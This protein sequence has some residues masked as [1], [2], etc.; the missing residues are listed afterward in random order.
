MIYICRPFE[1][2]KPIKLTLSI[3][4]ILLGGDALAGPGSIRGTV[5]GAG[6]ALISA[7]VA[8][9]G[10]TLGSSTDLQG[11]FLISAVEPGTYTLGV[12]Y[13]GHLPLR[14]TVRVVAD[15]VLDL[16]TLIMEPTANDLGEVVV[17]GTMKEMSRA[18]SPIPVEV[19]TP[20][21]F[22][23][24]P[25]PTLIGSV[26]M[27][28]GVRP[29]INCS[30]CNTG[31]IHING[32]EGP[33]TMVLI[34]GMPIVSGLSTVYGLSGIPTSLVERVEVVKGPGS[35]LYGSEAMGG[36]INVIT[37]DPALAPRV[38]VDVMGS[39][40]EEYNADLGATVRRGKVSNL[41]GINVFAYDA[42]RDNNGDGFTDMT[43]QK[44]V[45]IFNKISY[46][47]PD[48]KA[49]SLAARYVQEDRWGGEMDWTPAFAGSDLRYGETIATRRWEL[50]GQYQLPVPGTVM[51][52]VSMNGH[53]QESWYGTTPFDAVQQVFFGQLFWNRRWG[54]RH[55]VLTGLAY[56]FTA[57]NDNTP[58]TSSG[59]EPYTTD[60]PQ[61]KPMPGLFVQ[62]EWSLTEAHKLLLG[63]RLD[64]DVDH[65]LVHAPR[66][67]Y[68][69]APSGRWTVRASFGT[70]YRVVNL[71]TE[72]HAAL[73]GSRTVVITEELRP[74]RS[75]NG[76][77]NVVRKWV[78]EKRF[79]ALDG[80]VFHTRF[81]NRILPD[82]DTDPDLILYANLDGE[83]IAQGVSLNAEARLGKPLRIMAGATYMDVLTVREGVR[84]QQLF[85]PT[86]SGTFTAGIDLTPGTSM[87]LTGQWYGPMRLPIQPN[88]FRPAYSPWYALLNVQLK[89]RISER[90]E[91]YGGVKNLLDFVPDDPL[92]RPFDPFDRQANDPVSN[93]NG[94]SFDTSYIYAPMQGVRGFLGIRFTLM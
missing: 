33:Y 77:L 19:I 15:E 3:L 24:N 94:Y 83:G 10:T 58:A 44:R 4:C 48:R 31:D 36:I 76:T 60:R 1:A 92:M 41:T 65:G 22:R 45:S 52:Q 12:S 61:R 71:F 93:P 55:D 35:A 2:M 5:T 6:G 11:R 50:I 37:K 20:A 27:V 82:Y 68:K 7:N 53:H 70:G 86:W 54:A 67:A 63:Y 8:L 87:D 75:W 46:R 62:D 73:T 79:F 40:W 59:N 64:H 72:D 13:L 88:D 90:V 49:A 18:D 30:V 80:S 78:G 39:T 74:E 66:V 9:E 89:H 29:Q 43:L 26:G 21:L 42:P 34:D 25:E 47:R 57:Y 56:R 23:R 16:G 51:A 81:S 85:A 84:E 32:M 69:Y 38:S 28:N 17:T 14:R 91:C